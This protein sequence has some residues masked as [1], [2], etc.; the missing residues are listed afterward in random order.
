[1]KV[2]LA[3]FLLTGILALSMVGCNN[4]ANKGGVNAEIYS[5]P[6]FMNIMQD[7]DYADKGAAE[8]R[9]SMAKNEYESAQIIFRSPEDTTFNAVIE[10]DLMGPNG[11][12]IFKSNIEIFAQHY[13]NVTEHSYSFA[14]DG[15]YPD[16]L[17]PMDKYL[18]KR[19]NKVQKDKNQAVVITV[20]TSENT[21]AGEYSGNL[22]L[23][24]GNKYQYIPIRVTVWDFAVP[25]ENHAKTSFNI[26]VDPFPNDMLLPGELDSSEEM[27]K[28]YY[29]FFLKYKVSTSYLPTYSYANLDEYVKVIQEYAVRDEV[30]SYNIYTKGEL[31]SGTE[32]DGWGIDAA[33][34]EETLEAILS[35]CTAEEDLLAKAYVYVSSIDEPRTTA[36]YNRVMHVDK[37]ISDAKTKLA[38]KYEAS[39]FFADKPNVKESLL[40][41]PHISTQKWQAA[42]NDS[43]DTFCPYFSE[44]DNPEYLYNVT[45]GDG[46]DSG[47]WWYGC[48]S[49]TNPYPNYHTD[50]D[51]ISARILPWMQ[52]AYNIEG[53]L[54]WG[55]N[56]YKKWNGVYNTRDVW[57]DS[58]TWINP[59]GQVVSG[60][61]Q[62]VY[63]G[64]KYD[65]YGPIPTLRLTA[66]RDGNEDYE[67]LY[68]LENLIQ[69]SNEIYKTDYTLEDVVG[70]Y[71]TQL[72]SGTKYNVAPDE[73]SAA[74][75]Y[76]AQ[77]ILALSSDAKA[78]VTTSRGNSLDGTKQL[79][80]LVN[81][82]SKVVVNGEEVTGSVPSGS[83][84]LY[85]LKFDTNTAQTAAIEIRGE[86]TYKIDRFISYGI[87]AINSFE[88]N[89]S[90]SGI[91]VSKNSASAEDTVVELNT[92]ENYLTNGS[93][94]LKVT[95]KAVQNS[96]YSRYIDIPVPAN[97]EDFSE[98]KNI[99][100]DLIGN[101]TGLNSFISI[102]DSRSKHEFTSVY[103]PPSGTNKVT[104]KVTESSLVDINGIKYIRLGFS[105]YRSGADI[106]FY[107]DNMFV[108]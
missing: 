57:E 25:K 7:E 89:G 96:Q 11:A 48:I 49:P 66:I 87:K 41:L 55:V 10:S 56:I 81:D 60:D 76:V 30:A 85:S 3:T 14:K 97:L 31:Y 1:M 84:K 80:I 8:F 26:W 33:Y 59:G 58:C 4:D 44:Y 35:A 100:F 94:S 36:D 73:L 45:K 9:I 24:V 27:Y 70:E 65:V 42:Y 106:T 54:Y 105:A 95:L 86:K 43:V 99:S 5:A 82:D 37:I 39:G 28:A 46:A 101:G 17:V 2:R 98:V 19:D 72:F 77:M 23:V 74:R 91:R 102:L 40:N 34:F 93:G 15:Y 107:I 92:D 63:P 64:R 69:E 104:L 13:I 50:G 90:I 16:A 75:E 68:V 18:A 61:G 32:Y 51:L 108:E 6:V 62:L 88:D 78:L 53:N 22:K 83:G 20:K 47:K 38:E 29:E 103:I 79:N 52:K 71:Y 12:R 21:P 67:Y